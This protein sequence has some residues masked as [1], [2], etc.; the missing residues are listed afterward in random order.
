V[1]WYLFIKEVK[2]G[3]KRVLESPSDVF[4]VP[5]SD[6]A[7]SHLLFLG[8]AKRD[9]VFDEG[10]VYVTFRMLRRFSDIADVEDEGVPQIK[11]GSGVRPID[12]DDVDDWLTFIEQRVEQMR[13][14][15]RPVLDA[16]EYAPFIHLCAEVGVTMCY[17]AGSMLHLRAD[18]SVQRR[19]VRPLSAPQA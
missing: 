4:R 3:D 8:M 18:R 7:V 10:K 1:F 13:V 16:G 5:F 2:I 17:T 12:E 6:T 11:V 9:A 14:K 15:R 19:R